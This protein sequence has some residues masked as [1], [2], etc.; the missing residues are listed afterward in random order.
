[1]KNYQPKI[2]KSRRRFLN[3]TAYIASLFASPF[4]ISSAH[5]ELNWKKVVEPFPDA[6]IHYED[7]IELHL[8]QFLGNPLLINFWATWCAPCIIELP[9][10][11]KAVKHLK[12]NQ[13][14]ILLVS[15]DRSPKSHVSVFLDNQKI[16]NLLR[17]FDPQA[18]WARKL[19]V[20]ALPVTFLINSD[21][22]RGLFHIGAVD[23]SK[24]EIINEV[25]AKVALIDL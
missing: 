24:P 5:S 22:T 12:K 23:W 16:Y 25:N 20:S 17:G 15:T 11:D 13:I 1:M 2:Y 3:Q 9:H 8:K 21:Q 14:E 7:D 4:I 19:K 18:I 6:S 10:L